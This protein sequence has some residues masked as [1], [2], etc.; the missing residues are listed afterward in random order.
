MDNSNVQDIVFKLQDEN[1]RLTN[2]ISLRNNE[3]AELKINLQDQKN[4]Q[5]LQNSS[6]QRY[7]QKIAMLNEE[8]E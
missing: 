8:I 7:E 2:L 1:R 3:I 4:K 5:A 6:P